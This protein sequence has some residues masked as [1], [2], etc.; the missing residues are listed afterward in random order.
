[1]SGR[2][3]RF[4]SAVGASAL[5]VAVGLLLG[6]GVLVL[7]AAIPLVFVAY[8]SFS[9]TGVPTDVSVTRTLE[10]TK[11]P[12]E[13]TVGVTLTVTNEGEEII[14]DLRVI[15]GVPGELAVASGSPRGGGALAPGESF[16]I[17]Y[18]VTVRRGLHRFADPTVRTRGLVG[19]AVTT[20]SLSPDGDRTV[21]CRLS[22]EGPPLHDTGRPVTGRLETNEPG[23]GLVFHATREHQP[24]D[25]AHRLD[26]RH[27]AK[28]SELATV[29]YDRPV[30]TAVVI[31]V[32]ARPVNRVVPGPGRPSGLERSCYAAGRTAAALL[33]R[34]HDVGLA[35]V[36]RRGEHGAL[37]WVPPGQGRG[38]RNRIEGDLT[39]ALDEEGQPANPW[40]QVSRIIEL[41]P[42][43]GQ[44]VVLSPL[45]DEWPLTMVRQSLTAG[46]V[47]VISPDVIAESTVSGTFEAIERRARLANCQ[48]AGAH[49]IDWRRGTPL[50]VV[51]ELAF[52]AEKR[53][54]AT[55]TAPG[56]GA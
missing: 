3:R 39:W 54:G 15:D 22:V 48:G 6:S 25:P 30:R 52:A 13:G 11:V 14:E 24:T 21:D 8:S 33:E 23:E 44:L 53:T 26:W 32:D 29:T 47:T 46:P 49:V 18:R 9:S 28:T 51:L 5:L 43:A 55:A 38:Q 35:I 16:E 37:Q 4:R 41:T 17:D 31:A 36:G 19:G 34:G 12:P 50:Q 1:M 42:A 2:L 56:G 40:V 45:V 7:G 10:A 20:T 27:Y